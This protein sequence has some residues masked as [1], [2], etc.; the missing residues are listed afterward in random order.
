ML[1]EHLTFVFFYLAGMNFGA[2]VQDNNYSL[3]QII[4]LSAILL[5]LGFASRDIRDFFEIDLS[6]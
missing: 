4:H 3:S 1:E 6:Y 5:S 2:L